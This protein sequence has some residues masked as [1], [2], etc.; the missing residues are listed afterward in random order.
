MTNAIEI[1]VV[2]S[3]FNRC[4]L[5]SV[6]L[7]RIMSQDAGGIT[8]EVIVVDNNSADQTRHVVASISNGGN[9][10]LRYVFEASQGV[11]YARNSGIAKARAPIIAFL[12]DDVVPKRNWIR[13]IRTTFDKHPDVSCIGGRILPSWEKDPP[14][15]LTPEHWAPVALQDYGSLPFYINCDHQLC[16]LSANFAFRRE[17]FEMIGDFAPELQRVK[18]GIGSMEDLELLIRLWKANL[19]AL[20]VPE[21]IV[22]AQVPVDRMT[23]A[24]HRRWHRGHGYFYAMLRSD[25]VECSSSGRL[26]DVPAHLYRRS[27]IDSL[28]WLRAFCSGKFDEAF[29]YETELRFFMGF[30]SKRR[31]DFFNSDRSGTSSELRRIARSVVDRLRKVSL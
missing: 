30:F 1:S 20:Y 13:T 23:K 15:W 6:V 7:D 5:L 10:D 31:R 22:T 8:Y 21:L 9:P 12:D 11:S 27:L 3:T 2:I 17:V 16:L 26:F 24:Y 14:R 18:D 29:K 28:G 25:E 19:Q 4:D